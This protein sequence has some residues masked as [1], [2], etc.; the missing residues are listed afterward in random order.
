MNPYYISITIGFGGPVF[1]LAGFL[2]LLKS[3]LSRLQKFGVAITIYA[4]S[5]LTGT[6]ADC[7]WS[8]GSIV[9]G[10]V[11][12][13]IAPTIYCVLFSIVRQFLGIEVRKS[14]NRKPQHPRFE[15]RETKEEALPVHSN[16]WFLIIVTALIQAIYSLRKTF[17]GSQYRKALDTCPFPMIATPKTLS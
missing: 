2:L 17:W 8:L 5:I 9:A 10:T 4:L 11:A 13:L 14:N 15:Q 3:S 1:I 16:S 6:L 7:F 12:G